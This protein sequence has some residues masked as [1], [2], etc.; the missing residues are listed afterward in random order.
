MAAP[1]AKYLE[2]PGWWGC[3]DYY[4]QQVK[5]A[6]HAAHF[7]EVGAFQGRSTVSMGELVAASGKLI[8]FDVVDTWQGSQVSRDKA[9]HAKIIAELGR[10]LYD[11]FE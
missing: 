3:A 7:V 5:R 10:P 11:A 6:P 9:L 4:A 2:I 8:R 1:A